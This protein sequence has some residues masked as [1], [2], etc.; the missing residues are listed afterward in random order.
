MKKRLSLKVKL[1]SKER[2][3]WMRHDAE[4]RAERFLFDLFFRLPLKWRLHGTAMQ[5]GQLMTHA[6][7]ANREVPSVTVGE[8]IDTMTDIETGSK[9]KTWRS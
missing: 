8:L 3:V 7:L 5:I 9:G 4:V 1:P 6:R 2:R